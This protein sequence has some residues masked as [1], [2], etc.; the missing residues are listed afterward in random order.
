[1]KRHILLSIIVLLFAGTSNIIADNIL[2][3]DSALTLAVKNNLDIKKSQMEISR[4]K[5]VKNEVRGNYFPRVEIMGGAYHALNPILEYSIDDIPNANARDILNSLYAEYGAA[6]G[7]QKSLQVFQQTAMASATAV[8]PVFMG[9]KITAGNKLAD[10]GVKAADLQSDVTKRDILLTVEENYWLII[11]LEEKR[12]TIEAVELLLDTLHFQVQ[13]AIAAGVAMNNDLL[14]VELRQNEIEEQQQKLNNGIKLARLALS[15]NIGIPVDSIKELQNRV[16]NDTILPSFEENV[17][18]NRPEHQ[19]LDCKI[20]SEELQKKM[21]L[22][23]ALPQIA[24]GATY[25]YF[26]FS[27]TKYKTGSN[28]LPSGNIWNNRDNG[29]LFLTVKIPLSSWGM[30]SYKLKQHSASIAEAQ[31]DKLN[32]TQKMT[33]QEKQAHNSMTEAYS[34]IKRQQHGLISA[35]E[36]LRLTRL[37]Y[38]AG[39]TG[40]TELLQAQTL[41]L[42]AQNNLTDARIEYR[43]NKRKYEAL[44]NSFK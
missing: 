34:Q 13:K 38:D 4:A 16:D 37:N 35:Q 2:T 21:A 11:G 12:Q 9:G 32:L 30:T 31:I 19:L 5:A 24:I 36:N 20:K 7:L 40:I 26:G 39:L 15:Y 44:T 6:M 3:L 14:S 42:Q 23:D 27:S 28:A 33:L 17:I 10:I 43:V 41:L 1:M 22:A 25:S 8:Q 18:S 29:L